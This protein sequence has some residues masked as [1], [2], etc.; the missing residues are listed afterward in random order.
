VYD[1]D[2]SERHTALKKA[3]EE[4]G[5][6]GVFRKLDVVAKLSKRT[7]PEASKIFKADR[8]WIESNYKLRSP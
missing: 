7:A 3:V 6:L 4:F 1:K 5:A 2:Q 8:N